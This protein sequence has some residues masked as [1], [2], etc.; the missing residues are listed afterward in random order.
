MNAIVFKNPKEN[1][2]CQLL[3]PQIV[4]FNG[5]KKKSNE[6]PKKEIAITNVIK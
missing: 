3:F 4:V 5:N 1:D 2:P 6:V